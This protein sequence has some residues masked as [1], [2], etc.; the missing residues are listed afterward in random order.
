MRLTLD[1]A[2]RSGRAAEA[3]LD[4]FLAVPSLPLGDEL[5]LQRH[6]LVA[7]LVATVVQHDVDPRRPIEQSAKL[8]PLAVTTIEVLGQVRIE[9][10]V[11]HLV[12]GV[13]VHGEH[14]AEATLCLLQTAAGAELLVA[15]HLLAKM[16]VEQNAD[17]LDHRD[18]S[19]VSGLTAAHV[20]VAPGPS[21]AKH[22]ILT[23][24]LSYV[25]LVAPKNFKRA[26]II[27]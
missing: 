27:R 7:V 23:H 18:S 21:Q 12:L 14:G 10:L 5:K 24:T 4:V 15:L 26:R 25:K 11:V 3:E 17:S 13:K 1:G 22:V 6:A 16:R 19:F 8:L 9:R 20:D 2:G